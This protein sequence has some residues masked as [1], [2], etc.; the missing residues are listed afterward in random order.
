MSSYYETLTA[1]GTVQWVVYVE[2]GCLTFPVAHSTEEGARALVRALAADPSLGV[3]VP[4]PET[5]VDAPDPLA[6]ARARCTENHISF[7]VPPG[8]VSLMAELDA[9]IAE[10]APDLRYI[11]V[12]QKFA[13]LRVYTVRGNPKADRLITDAEYRSRTICEVC[14]EV[15]AVMVSPHGWYRT[16]CEPHAERYGCI[17]P[18]P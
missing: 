4:M 16:L 2:D 1:D 15:G 8:W 13:E 10:V 6:S 3:V 12:K 14:G 5:E 11:Q 7:D 17:T 18:E 9:A